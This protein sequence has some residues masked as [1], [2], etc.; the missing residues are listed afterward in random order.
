MG[1]RE[2][3]ETEDEKRARKAAKKAK[4]ASKAEHGGK[5]ATKEEEVPETENGSE[6]TGNSV[7]LAGENF[8]SRA[9]LSS[10][11]ETL[12]VAGSSKEGLT[13]KRDLKVL[14]ALLKLHPSFVPSGKITSVH[15]GE[16]P[17]F[18][19][20]SCFVVKT[21]DSEVEGAPVGFKK[22]VS[23]LFGKGSKKDKAA[24]AETKPEASP[25]TTKAEAAD[26]S[27]KQKSPKNTDPADGDFA[28]S[29]LP[30]PM[31]SFND[32]PF[33]MPLKNALNEAYASP[34]PIQAQ[35]WPIALGGSDLIAV[36]KTGSGKTLGFLMPALHAI[37]GKK[38]GGNHVKVLVLAPTRE[39][40]AQ[41]NAEC[42]KF[43]PKVGCGSACVY[44]GVPIGAQVQGI[45]KQRPAV[46]VAT[47]GR[48]CDL[49]TRQKMDLSKCEY[50]VLDEADR[51]L[52]M[53][54]EKEIEQIFAA[55]P[56]KE[57]V[58]GGGQ[59]RQTLLFSA[60][61]PKAV[62]KLAANY[63]RPSKTTRVFIGTNADAELEANKAVSQTFI[64]ATD[65]EKDNKLWEFL[66]TLTDGARVVVFANT[67]RRVDVCARTF[68]DFGTVAIH[69]DK[70]QFERD[71]ALASF[72]QNEKPLMFATDVAARGLDIKGV[73][74]VINFDMARD[75]ESYVHRIGRTGRAGE[76]G[77]AIT[78]WNPDYDKVSPEDPAH[79]K[80][81][82]FFLKMDSCL[83]NV[84]RRHLNTRGSAS[85][86][87]CTL[88]RLRYF[89]RFFHYLR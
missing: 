73:T 39:L 68:S 78:F 19:G 85:S 27:A 56:S 41:I 10:R 44:G 57:A 16:H 37:S 89:T 23:K 77:D 17:R 13:S 84:L 26:S 4:K 35:A 64:H 30:P 1:K 40:T 62:R 79:S 83:R 9:D 21:A 15:F 55:L 45:E 38:S 3:S 50:V 71:A 31:A 2:V 49:L 8:S 5:A 52:D 82:T 42:E 12:Q 70:Q 28:S 48:L 14:K 43:G 75:V 86:T 67:K 29:D 61:W 69:G 59:G 72:V 51:M 53:G 76:L 66:G 74:H 18:P 46:V 34:T 20:D 7:E 47:P 87:K 25:A 32:T 88:Q 6:A 36:A 24:K 65:D 63:L 58:G 81:S 80:G 60:T 22:V 33:A 54:F 11:I